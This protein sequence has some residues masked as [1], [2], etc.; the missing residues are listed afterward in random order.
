MKA[1]ICE[2]IK[3]GNILIDENPQT[4]SVEKELDGNELSMVQLKEQGNEIDDEY[5]WACPIC[6][7]DAHLI[8]L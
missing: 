7:D 3:C 6:E 5:F 1:H 4:D 2:C 8:D